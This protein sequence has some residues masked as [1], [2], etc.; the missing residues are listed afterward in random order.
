MSLTRRLSLAIVFVLVILV[1]GTFGYRLIEGWPLLDALYMTIITISTVGFGE[2]APLSASGRI[3]TILLILGGA[4]TIIF[5]FGTLV[6]FL[7]EGH[8]TG[9]LGRRKMEKRIERLSDHYI[10][11]GLGRVGEQIAK[12]LV[13]A[14]VPFVIIDNN[15][16]KMFKCEQEDYPYIIGDAAEDEVLAAAGVERAKGLIA[17]V[18]N[19]GDNVFIALSAKGVNPSIFVVARAENEGSEPKLKKAGADRVVSPVA[20]GGRRMAAL[21]LRPLVC[22]YLD[23]MAH[24]EDIEFQ[25]EESELS[26][27]SAIAGMSIKAAGVRDKTGVFILAI[28]KADGRILANPASSEELKVGDKLVIMGTKNQLKTW[29]DFV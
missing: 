24:G 1:S 9:F 8:L 2:V 23:I 4:G 17:V 27:G 26:A 18:D 19:D 11:C 13:Q 12:E 6:E 29:N 10:L 5:A 14:N 25:L 15:P 16:D 28:K 20:I 7:V 21:V 22:D 3:F